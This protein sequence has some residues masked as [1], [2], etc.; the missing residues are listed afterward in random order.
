MIK[1]RGFTPLEKAAD[2]N[3]RS[4]QIEADG[5]IKPP[6][7]QTVRELSSLT[8]FTLIE[9]MI[10][11]FIMLIVFVGLLSIVN[12]SLELQESSKNITI[13]INAVRQRIEEIRYTPFNNIIS[14]YNNTPSNIFNITELNGR[15]RTTII[16]A[17]YVNG[18]DN[19]NLLN[20][21]AVICWR[22]KNGRI[23]GED[24]N[25]NGRLDTGEDLNSN[26]LIDSPCILTT[27]IASGQ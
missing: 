16:R 18:T 2:F 17:T 24:I 14:L 9:L 5:G 13:A 15:G 11:L 19:P 10:S 25:L 23:I 26:G 21:R 12:Y 1:I 22:Q 27:A 6:S 7:A 4:S 3:R 8:G 20:V